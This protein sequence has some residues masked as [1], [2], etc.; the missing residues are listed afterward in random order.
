M[1]SPISEETSGKVDT[2]VMLRLSC[3]II[4]KFNVELVLPNAVTKIVELP[5]AVEGIATSKLRFKLSEVSETLLISP[6]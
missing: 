3:I 4:A 5:E 2:N 1:D 6:D